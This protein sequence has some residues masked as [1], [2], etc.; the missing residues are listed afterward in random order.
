MFKVLAISLT[1]AAVPALAEKVAPK[2]V[3][4]QLN[5]GKGVEVG[6]LTITPDGDGVR[7]VVDVKGLPPGEHALHF[8]ENGSCIGPDF[9]SAGNHFSP[10]KRKHGFDTKGGPHEGDL[11]NMT[12]KEDGTGHFEA[13][14]KDVALHGKSLLKPK[15][16]SFVIH[17]KPDDYK[18]QPSGAS[19]DRIACGE[20]KSPL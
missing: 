7:V 6:S 8:H 14:L 16:T 12:V 1:F 18:T 20:V 13:V 15:G 5:N 17:E 9:K 19:G 3:A 11:Q 10:Q 4:V 2:P